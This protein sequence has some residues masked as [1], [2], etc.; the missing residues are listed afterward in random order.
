MVRQTTSHGKDFTMAVHPIP[1][2]FHS[3]T[4]YITV[5]GAPHFIDFLTRAFGATELSRTP[6]A[7]GTIMHAALRIGDSIV[8]LSEVRPGAEPT[9]M[10]IHLYVENMDVVY[11]TAIRAGAH[12]VS[13]P[14]YQP[15]GDQE[16]TVTDPFGNT[17]YISTHVEDVTAEEIASRMSQKS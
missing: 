7:D 1:K 11:H 5:S 10:A 2:G 8:E 13:E 17:W 9:R 16:S 15:Y 6:R 4:P 3:I 12:P 14:T